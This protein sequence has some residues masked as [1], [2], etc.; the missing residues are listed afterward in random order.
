MCS[1]P[2]TINRIRS[3][4]DY[5]AKC[6]KKNTHVKG[7]DALR[8]FRLSIGDARLGLLSGDFTSEFELKI[9]NNKNRNLWMLLDLAQTQP[10]SHIIYNQLYSFFCPRVCFLSPGRR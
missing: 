10:S 8:P 9:S 4:S 2:S 7:F 6:K 3:S 1:L 5:D